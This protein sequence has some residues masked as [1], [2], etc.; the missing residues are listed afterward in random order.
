MQILV[1]KLSFLHTSVQALK[2]THRDTRFLITIIINIGMIGA[3][4]RS[5]VAISN[6][7]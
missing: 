5:R 6:E 2:H 1:N 4:A 3:P 7:C